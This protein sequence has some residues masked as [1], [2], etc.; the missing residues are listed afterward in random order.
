MSWNFLYNSLKFCI[1]QFL[2]FPWTHETYNKQINVLESQLVEGQHYP[3]SGQKRVHVESKNDD[4]IEQRLP[5]KNI[6]IV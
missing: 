6:K 2:W 3:S 4:Y 1:N 5:G